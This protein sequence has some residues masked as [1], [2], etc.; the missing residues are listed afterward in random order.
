[1]FI[2]KNKLE[3]ILDKLGKLNN[4]D[5]CCECGAVYLKSALQKVTILTDSWLCNGYTRRYCP[6]HKKPYDIKKEISGYDPK[7][8]KK[9]IHYY[10]NKV[11]VDEKGKE[12]KKEKCQKES[13]S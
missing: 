3:K 5:T 6:R 12:I 1:M 9:T 2:S 10:K 13:D 7:T 11:E 8:G 4:Y